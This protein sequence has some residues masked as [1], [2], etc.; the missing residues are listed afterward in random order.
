VDFNI[1]DIFWSS[2]IIASNENVNGPM[3]KRLKENDDIANE[4]RIFF[5][6]YSRKFNKCSFSTD[7][8][9][10]MQNTTFHSQ[11]PVMINTFLTNMLNFNFKY[12]ISRFNMR[13]LISIYWSKN[14]LPMIDKICNLVPLTLIYIS[15]YSFENTEK[16]FDLYFSY[17]GYWTTHMT[18]QF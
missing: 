4:Y 14:I 2:N 6:N 18:I 13:N 16:V 7:E 11:M 17:F 5:K 15:N 10:I 8:I 12:F 9:V 1:D 3:V